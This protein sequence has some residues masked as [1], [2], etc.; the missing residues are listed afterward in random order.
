M[1]PVTQRILIAGL[2]AA[3]VAVLSYFSGLPL[4][5]HR[6]VFDIPFGLVVGWI[7]SAGWFRKLQGDDH[8]T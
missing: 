5:D 1:S 6:L 2:V 4:S 7:S 8:P 3:V